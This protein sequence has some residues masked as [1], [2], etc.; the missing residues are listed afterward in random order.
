VGNKKVLKCIISLI[1]SAITLAIVIF[2]VV[3]LNQGTTPTAYDIY[4][5]TSEIEIDDVD[6]EV[7]SEETND[8]YGEDEELETDNIDDYESDE[9]L[10]IDY[11]SLAVSN[12]LEENYSSFHERLFVS[13]ITDE[14]GRPNMDL[15]W[16]HQIF[17]WRIFN[18]PS[19][20]G[21]LLSQEE[22]DA[23]LYEF[24]TRGG[25]RNWREF[26]LITFIE[27]FNFTREDIIKAQEETFGKPMEE[28]D[29][30]INWARNGTHT[31]REQQNEAQ[32]WEIRYSFSDIEAL[33]SND[34]YKLWAAFP[35]YGVMRNGRAY[36][37]EWIMNNIEE[38]M[39][40]EQIPLEY[41]IDIMNA[42]NAYPVLSE[43][44]SRAI[45]GFRRG[46]TRMQIPEDDF[47]PIL[48]EL[49]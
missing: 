37:P 38:A 41:I 44:N 6:N 1:A 22:F 16:Y 28:I 8:Y 7:E 15:E 4:E 26:S 49:E 20:F 12:F 40:D 48:A 9:E 39:I 13:D 35:G 33:F 23:W 21:R 14:S 11:D 29:E 45:L 10:D 25:S 24:D 2:V 27:D 5:V 17:S 34:V 46:L 30:L 47:A 32:L 36:S 43:V 31:M 42:S 3:S 18:I 19:M